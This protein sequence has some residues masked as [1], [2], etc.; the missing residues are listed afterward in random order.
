M[1]MLGELPVK[2]EEKDEATLLFESA[3][4][5]MEIG[6]YEDIGIGPLDYKRSPFE[7]PEE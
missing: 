6:N 2:E 3:M 4:N 5:R 7:D 1:P